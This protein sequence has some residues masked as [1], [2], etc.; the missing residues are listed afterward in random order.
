MKKIVTIV[1][2]S[3]LF[4]TA[5]NLDT[6]SISLHSSENIIR[7]ANHLFCEKD[8][9]RASLE[10]LRI[11]DKKRDELTTLKLGLSYSYLK[12]YSLASMVLEKINKNSS[13]HPYAQLEMLKIYLLQ[14]EFTLLKQHAY[15]DYAVNP[16]IKNVSKKLYNV[17]LL[18]E[19]E[20]LPSLEEFLA[21]FD[22]G[23]REDFKNFYYSKMNP[24][25]KSPIKA[26]LFSAIIPGSGKIY[27]DEIGDGIY[28]FLLTGLFA[29]L[30]YDNFQAEHDFRAWLF[31]GLSAGFYA[32]NVYGSYASAQIY[33]ARIKY[34]FNFKLDSLLKSKNYFIPQF[35]LCD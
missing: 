23:E 22:E 1:F 30:A 26:A 21:P 25:Y 6:S 7:F 15:N 10:Y 14:N 33:N 28:A 18:K 27:T 34:E 8:Y 24:D 17:T 5:Q 20:T 13:Y 32:G 11:D 29:F 4:L 2:S 31:A 12:E 16:S 35:K 3:T 9:L 19:K